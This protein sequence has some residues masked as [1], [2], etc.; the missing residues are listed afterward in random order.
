MATHIGYGGYS[1]VDVAAQ[2]YFSSDDLANTP[3][4]CSSEYSSPDEK[5]L[6]PEDEQER[7][8]RGCNFIHNVVQRLNM[9]QFVAST[10]CV[11]FHRFYMRQS[12]AKYH[13]Y[14]GGACVLLASKVEENKRGLKEISRACAHVALK[15]KASEADKIHETW[16]RLLK[17]QEIVL[18]ESCCFDLEI[19]HPYAAIDALAAESGVPV[20]IAKAATAH[21]NDCLRSTVCL[22][23]RPS[24]VAVAALYLAMGIH[25]YGFA[26]NLFASRAVELPANAEREVELCVMDMLDFYQ[27]EAD[28]EKQQQQ[29][30]H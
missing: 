29:R 11:L 21:V 18:L 16:E 5:A 9:H 1:P 2:W 7:R 22:R 12:L 28:A 13:H 14:M 23:F 4:Q 3:S 30:T 15:G 8:L 19:T 20:F 25:A 6:T 27:R 17:R 24:V 10:A 26:G